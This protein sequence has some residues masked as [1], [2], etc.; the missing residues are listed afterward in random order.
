MKSRD[1]R[2]VNIKKLVVK[3]KKTGLKFVVDTGA[4]VSI[5]PYK[6]TE[7]E[8]IKHGPVYHSV[9]GGNIKTFGN[10]KLMID[11][12]LGRNFIHDF[13]RA[14]ISD[15]ILGLDF[16]GKFDLSVSIRHRALYNCK[17]SRKI[18]GKI[19]ENSQASIKTVQINGNEALNQLLREFEDVTVVKETLPPIKHN[20]EHTIEVTGPIHTCKPRRVSPKMKL[21]MKKKLEGMIKSGLCS[22]SKSQWGS[23][24]F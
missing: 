11:I 16:L 4:D 8:E 14:D 9:T 1:I 10:V 19:E 21:L 23:H 7:E 15:P 6:G 3:C 22:P 18:F 12:G 13:V 20:V 5:I 17:N 24:F 2:S